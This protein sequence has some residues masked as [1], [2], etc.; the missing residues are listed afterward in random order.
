[1]NFFISWISRNSRTWTFI[2]RNHCLELAG[3][4]MFAKAFN[5]NL[6]KSI[7]FGNKRWC[8]VSVITRPPRATWIY[9]SSHLTTFPPRRRW[10]WSWGSAR[11]EKPGFARFRFKL[12][13]FL[14]SDA[15]Y[16]WHVICCLQFQSCYCKLSYKSARLVAVQYFFL[17]PGWRNKEMIHTEIQIWKTR[18]IEFGN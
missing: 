17:L 3:T 10:T 16:S 11:Q 13:I 15:I 4:L 8:W 2:V 14:L 12:R 7:I 6:A 9:K 5:L 18:I 1:M